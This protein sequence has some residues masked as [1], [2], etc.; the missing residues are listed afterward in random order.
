MVT[1]VS[2]RLL[3]H[4]GGLRG[5]FR[6]DVA[7]LARVRGLGDA[8]AMRVKAVLELGRRWSRSSCGWCCQMPSLASWA[9]AP[10]IRASVN[11][12]R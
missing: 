12:K 4:H 9:P 10:S 1:D 7:E 6:L 5:L 2:Q 11:Q 8:K 3:A